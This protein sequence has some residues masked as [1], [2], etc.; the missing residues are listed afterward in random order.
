MQYT[1]FFAILL[2]ILVAPFFLIPLKSIKTNLGYIAMLVP[3]VSLVIVLDIASQSSLP[4]TTF[5]KWIPE[6]GI[7]L[8]FL[9]DKV[10][11]FFTG[12]T[13]LMG[14]LIGLYCQSY[15]KKA[16]P[17]FYIYLMLFMTSM[18][19]T[20]VSNNIGL[21]IVFWELTAI[22]SFLLIGFNTTTK[23]AQKGALMTLLVT[24]I[25]GLC[26]MA[27]LILVALITQFT[28]LSDLIEIA[29]QLSSLQP[30][31]TPAFILILIGILGKS[32]QFPFHFW[33]PKAMSAPAPVS[34]Y[35]HSAAM[36]KLGIFLLAR[37]YPIFS[38][39]SLWTPTLLTIGVIT[40]VIGAMYAV[41]SHDIKELLAYSTISQLGALVLNFAMTSAGDSNSILF[42]I[43]NHVVYKGALFMAAGIAIQV[44]HT[45]D[46]RKM[47]GLLKFAPIAAIGAIIALASMMAIPGTTGFI[48]KEMTLTSLLSLQIS[49]D[50]GILIAAVI[51]TNIALIIAGSRLIMIFFGPLKGLSEEHIDRPS[52]G[53]QLPVILSASIAFIFGTFPH[54]QLSI[55]LMISLFS[56]SVGITLSLVSYYKKWQWGPCPRWANMGSHCDDVIT[57]IRVWSTKMTQI[58]KTD[59]PT[60]YLPITLGFISAILL[61]IMMPLFPQIMQYLYQDDPISSLAITLAGIIAAGAIAACIVPHAMHRLIALSVVGIVVCFYFIVYQAP[62]LAITQL[63]IEA[64][65]LVF[66]VILLKRLPKDS[67]DRPITVFKQAGNLVI[68]VI[69]GC[70]ATSLIVLMTNNQLI[71]SMSGYFIQ[72]TQ[73]LAGGS[74]T[75]NTILVDFRG[76]DTM[77]E[78]SV[79]IIAALGVVGV[80]WTKEAHE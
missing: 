32:A 73:A 27:G 39:N 76:F 75:V 10:S 30:Y 49:Y 12:V 63:M 28:Q 7:H 38:Q 78:I 65:G 26:L 33:L 43:L 72:N 67:V 42:Q 23:E 64:I 37:L 47:S 15:F 1:L 29:P 66:M 74:N 3:L 71:E 4:Q 19:G 62:D 41:L 16:S 34:A 40:M 17:R 5:L 35:L 9:I 68:S 77:G 46:I 56:L 51:V 22:A 18:M 80:L 25:T 14:A 44:F 60:Q 21:L 52:F 79:L 8:S 50:A 55:P 2:P 24:S 36:V 59:T 61:L 6:L 11:L 53:I 31:L 58:V 20:V 45:Q 69:M 70:L 57:Q 48:S 54:M 13:C